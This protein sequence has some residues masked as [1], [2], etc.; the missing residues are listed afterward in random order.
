MASL[1]SLGCQRDGDRAVHYVCVCDARGQVLPHIAREGAVPVLKHEL[2]RTRKR[3]A[4]G[5]CY[6]RFH[7]F[8]ELAKIIIR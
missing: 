6:F 4:L 3:R 1:L 8:P 2:T 7:P 5:K